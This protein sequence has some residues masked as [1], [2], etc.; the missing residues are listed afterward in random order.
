LSRRRRPLKASLVLSNLSL[1][2]AHENSLG[3]LFYRE[4]FLKLSLGGFQ[5]G[6]LLFAGGAVFCKRVFDFRIRRASID[7]RLQRLLFSTYWLSKSASSAG[8][9][10]S[11]ARA[12]LPAGTT[13]AAGTA[14]T[15]HS[16]AAIADLATR[17]HDFL[18]QS[19]NDV[20]FIVICD[21]KGLM[22]LVH[23]SLLHLLLELGRIEVAAAKTPGA[24]EAATAGSARTSRAPVAR[25][26]RTT[27]TAVVIL[28]HQASAAQAK[29]RDHRQDA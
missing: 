16:H 11:T 28:G 10:L 23:L 17:V 1:E 29:G 19:L 4:D 9:A 7:R 3:F 25:T 12:S 20:P 15:A 8:A 2:Q 6:L 18:N 5:L 14:K 27:G 13:L 24:T 26:A 21:G 22:N